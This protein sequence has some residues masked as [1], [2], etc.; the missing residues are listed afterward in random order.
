MQAT[1]DRCGSITTKTKVITSKK[2]ETQGKQYTVMVC[3]SGCKAGKW[4]YTFFPP[5]ERND[6]KAQ[7][8]RR[9]AQTKPASGEA[10]NLLRSIDTTMKNILN[11][12]QQK[13]GMV[14]V[15]ENELAPDEDVPF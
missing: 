2:P 9:P 14:S 8:E 15:Q 1:C 13:A 7:P 10:T 12:L 6:G 11:I 5:Q 4:D 3:T